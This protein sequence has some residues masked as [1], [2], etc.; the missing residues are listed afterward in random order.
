MDTS[1]LSTLAI[2][3]VVVLGVT[4]SGKTTAGA[5][6][7]RAIN[8]THIELDALHWGPD[9]TPVEPE[10]LRE[11]V[12]TAVG[13]HQRWVTDG[14]YARFVWDITWV[15]TDVIVWLDYPLPLSMW[16]L[17][18]RT[19]RRVVRKEVLWSGNR[20]RI[21]NHLASRDSLFLWAI[22]SHRKYQR[23]YPEYFA[24]QELAHVEA[25]RFRKPMDYERWVAGLERRSAIATPR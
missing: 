23:S 7:A 25:L 21:A 4:G 9:W 12:R 3:R 1:A 17:L 14:G 15:A 5:R 13:K 24:R 22:R 8:A 2:Q 16:R 18:K 10:V 19:T 6:I 11:L 20:E